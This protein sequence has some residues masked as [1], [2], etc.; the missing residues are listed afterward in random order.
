M[1]LEC[2]FLIVFSYCVT[3][4][5]VLTERPNFVPVM[6]DSA[7]EDLH[8]VFHSPSPPA[9]EVIR[10]KTEERDRD[11]SVGVPGEVNEEKT[12]PDPNSTSWD[13]DNDPENPKNWPESKKWGMVVL[14]SFITFL[15]S[16]LLSPRSLS[17]AE[18]LPGR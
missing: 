1:Y 3:T 4:S 16:A 10:G 13:G 2:M 17:T 8:G 11:D 9:R 7:S 12:T 18:I 15:T 5:V 14:L 6:A